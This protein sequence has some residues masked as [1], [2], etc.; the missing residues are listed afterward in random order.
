[1]DDLLKV[2][3]LKKYFTTDKGIVKAVDGVSFSIKAGETLGLVGESG[4]G[5]TTVAFTLIGGYNPTSGEIHFKEHKVTEKQIKRSREFIRNI[6]IV[7]QDPGSSLNPK[8]SIKE[9]L[10]MPLKVHKICPPK[11]R[12]AKI[13]ELLDLV[14][15]PS[16]FIYK[17]PL[18]LGEGE[19]QSVAIA[20]ALAVTPALIVLDEPTSSLDVSMQAKIINL[21][22][23]LQKDFGLSFLF[24]TH[25]LSLMRNVS[26]RVAIMYLGKICEIADTENFFER[27]LHPYTRMLLSSIPV[28]SEDEEKMKPQKIKPRGEIPSPVNL[29]S[30]CGFHPRCPDRIDIC[31][32]KNP[33]GNIIKEDQT[34]F[35]HKYN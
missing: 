1:M 31:D 6:Q 28:V 20:R 34:V 26:S 7:F 10:S 5:K 23:G 21:L 3:N 15:L 18:E 16:D 33:E 35:C 27:P 30:G 8:Q 17:Y 24:I 9:I 4:S 32:K 25:D 19:K 13:L 22:L 14:Q 12:E 2:V 11:E 29:P